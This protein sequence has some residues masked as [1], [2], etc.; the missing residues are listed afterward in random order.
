MYELSDD[1]DSESP[2]LD[3]PLA[4]IV[5]R[6]YQKD[7]EAFALLYEHFKQPLGKRLMALVNNKETAYDLYQDTFVRVWNYFSQG[8]AERQEDRLF[9]I[10][11]FQVWLYTVARNVA[12]DYIRH[13]KKFV[14]LPLFEDKSN[15][16]REYVLARLQS[17]GHEDQV[18]EQLYLQEALAAMSPKYRQCLLLHLQ[19]GYS[20]A[21][22]ALKLG[23]SVM[24]VDSNISRGYK[25]LRK[26]YTKM[27]SDR[28]KTRK[29]GH[30][31]NG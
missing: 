21:E 22:I 23:M 15:E 27:K 10:H 13:N 14:F 29:G 20:H 8:G 30:K 7:R 12:V 16:Y 25:Q 28:C 31:R 24:A 11:H 5:A 4:V 17:D 2:D 1:S 3:A 26:I 9:I 6:A 19:W 18:C